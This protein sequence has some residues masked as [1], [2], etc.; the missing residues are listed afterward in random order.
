MVRDNKTLS[1]ILGIKSLNG[2]PNE[3][4]GHEESVNSCGDDGDESK[5]KYSNHNFLISFN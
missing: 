5:I 3:Q 1:L 4:M 2:N